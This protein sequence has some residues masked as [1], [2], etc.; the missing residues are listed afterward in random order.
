MTAWSAKVFSSSICVSENGET[1]RRGTV[2]APTGTRSRSI[3]TAKVV[4]KPDSTS[5]GCVYFRSTAISGTC[6]TDP[7]MIARAVMLPG[8]GAIGNTRST[9]ASSSSVHP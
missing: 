7:V 1:S 5:V 3:G 2:I 9:A 4:R 6:T 8:P